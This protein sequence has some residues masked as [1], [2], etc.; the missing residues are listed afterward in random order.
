M[1]TP[2]LIGKQSNHKFR[3]SIRSRLSLLFSGFV[4]INLVAVG[5]GGIGL[6]RVRNSGPLLDTMGSARMLT[7]KLAYLA[8][9]RDEKTSLDRVALE[10]TIREDI[11]LF[12]KLLAAMHQGSTQLGLSPV[13]NPGTLAQL[14]KVEDT[15]KI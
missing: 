4:V 8:N 14:E 13:T 5:I 10:V 12:E 1:I 15:W 3:H 11:Q 6:N 9:I 7:Y 2:N